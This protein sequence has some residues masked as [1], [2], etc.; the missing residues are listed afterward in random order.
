[1]SKWSANFQ[2]KRSKVKVTGSQKP[3][4][5][6]V[7]FTYGRPIKRVRPGADCKLL[8]HSAEKTDQFNERRA[9]FFLPE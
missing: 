3:P 9:C 4:Q 6:V 5:S 2:W 7:M 8:C 1:M